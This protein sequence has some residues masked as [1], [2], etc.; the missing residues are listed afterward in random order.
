[1]IALSFIGALHDQDALFGAVASDLTA[2]GVIDKIASTPGLRASALADA[3]AH[4][5]KHV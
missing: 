4:A 2:F 3:H 5:R 1:M